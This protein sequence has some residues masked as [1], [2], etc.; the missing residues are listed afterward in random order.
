MASVVLLVIAAFSLMIA[1]GPD[2][3]LLLP[4]AVSVCGVVASFTRSANG[5]FTPAT[6]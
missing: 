5:H 2:L 6:Q 3:L 1:L 4:A